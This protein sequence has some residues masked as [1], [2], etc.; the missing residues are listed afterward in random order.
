MHGQGTYTWQNPW[1]QYVGEWKNGK[2]DGQGTY[3]YSDGSVQKGLW[4]NGKFIGK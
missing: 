3:T 1:E 4:K 2:Q